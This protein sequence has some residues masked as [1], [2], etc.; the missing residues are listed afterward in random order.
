M[1][2]PLILQ[3]IS[4]NL[5]FTAVLLC[6]CVCV[7]VCV[8][9]LSHSVSFSVQNFNLLCLIKWALCFKGESTQKRTHNYY[10][11]VQTK[12]HI[13]YLEVSSIHPWF[14][15]RSF[16]EY[17]FVCHENACICLM[18]RFYF[19]YTYMYILWL[20]PLILFK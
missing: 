7:C 3:I 8:C 2:H 17:L 14:S 9:D 4:Q 20:C 11:V 6:V 10:Y 12:N 18:R 1:Q 15:C 13:K 16:C 5:S 19:G